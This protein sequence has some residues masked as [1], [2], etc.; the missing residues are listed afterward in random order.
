MTIFRSALCRGILLDMM[1]GLPYLISRPVILSSIEDGQ[2]PIGLYLPGNRVVL[3]CDS[4]A[5]SYLAEPAQL[6]WKGFQGAP[7]VLRVKT[8]LCFSDLLVLSK[9]QCKDVR[10]DVIF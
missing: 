4:S 10:H 5:D 7:F 6:P 8:K 1:Y 9:T 2:V 3:D